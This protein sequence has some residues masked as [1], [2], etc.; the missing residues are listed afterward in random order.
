MPS[1]TPVS[2]M[3]SGGPAPGAGLKRQ[4]VV[5]PNTQRVSL[6]EFNPATAALT[7]SNAITATGSFYISGTY[8]V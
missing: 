8:L 6:R 4:A 5:F 7:N 3:Q 1:S 2:I